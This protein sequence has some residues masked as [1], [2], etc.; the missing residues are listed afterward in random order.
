MLLGAQRAALPA[1]TTQEIINVAENA[2]QMA[3]QAGAQ[4]D[5]TVPKNDSIWPNAK[6]L[7]NAAYRDAAG[8]WV[9]L[10]SA[11]S[12]LDQYTS[13]GDL[14][15]DGMD[16]AAV[17]LNEPDA[18]GD[19]HYFLAAML[20]QGGVMFEAAETP[21]GGTLNVATHG[22]NAGKI[23]INGKQYRLFGVSLEQF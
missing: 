12:F 3:A 11:V 13:F 16:D 15:H 5:F 2:V 23:D 20:N 6:D 7:R 21:L 1:S 22:I 10:G 17:I 8:R 14:N 9:R 19:A 18:Q 4:I